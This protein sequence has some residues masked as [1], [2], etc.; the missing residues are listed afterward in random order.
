VMRHLRFAVNPSDAGIYDRVVVT[1]IIKQIAQTANIDANSERDFK[2]IVLTEVD[3]LTKEAQHALR[4]TMEKYVSTCRI[5][6]CINSLSR[7][8][9][10]I[11]SRCLAVRVAAPSIDDICSI[12]A[13]ICRKENITLPAEMAKNIATTS[14]RNL[15]RAILML[16]AAKVQKY[17]FTSNQ[18]IPDVDWKIFLR[19]TAKKIQAEQ[20]PANM[21]VVRD[22]LYELL[23]HGIPTETIF[24]ELVTCLSAKCDIKVKAQII[25]CASLYEHRLLAGNKPIFHLEAFVAKFMCIYKKFQDDMSE[26]METDE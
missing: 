17:P 12:L 21:I 22:R 11:K 19:E 9:P 3:D 15:R 23:S 7:V 8:I 26:M 20:T 24:R 10:A 6:L 25:S 5:F 14:D 13:N 2:V 16:E 18:H 1:D 4:R